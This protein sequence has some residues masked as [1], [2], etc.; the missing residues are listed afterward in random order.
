MSG[1]RRAPAVDRA[2][3]ILNFLAAHPTDAFSMSELSRLLG[4][5][6]ASMHAVLG[7]LTRSGYVERHP[8]NRTYRLGPGLV[9][10]GQ[11]ALTQHRAIAE[12]TTEIE[13][14]SRELD[15]EV[16]VTALIGGD[17]VYVG[18]AGRP[19]LSAPQFR[20][21]QR[22]PCVPP[23]GTVHMAWSGRDEIDAWL[24]T[25]PTPLT[26]ERRDKQLAIL[27]A[28]R[29]RGYAVGLDLGTAHIDVNRMS[30]SLGDAPSRAD[31]KRDIAAMFERLGQADYQLETIDPDETYDISMI[32]APV[33]DPQGRVAVAITLAGLPRRLEAKRA[34]E[35]A[36]TVTRTARAVSKRI[37]G[38]PPVPIHLSP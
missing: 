17:M 37:L 25:A 15:L 7:A 24:D 5:N 22:V 29:T 30:E 12:A 9:V 10:V 31:L 35:F 16:V 11:A 6:G 14:L 36:E 13:G 8:R 33:F 20:V 3:E 19:Q 1:L 26:D 2:I 21:G 34:V 28:V 38:V 4:I 27:A 23:Y 18:S 32:S